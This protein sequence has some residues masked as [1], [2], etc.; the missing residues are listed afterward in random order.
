MDTAPLPRIPAQPAPATGGLRAL[1]VLAGL[2]S[3][4]LVLLGLAL[5]VLQL[6]AGQ[7]APGTGLAAAIGPTWP[8]AL[9]QLGV[10]LAGEIVVLLRGRLGHAA[11]TWLAVAV[12]VATAVVLYLAWWA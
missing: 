1:E 2:C 4:G 7:I 6:T 10:G 9:G 5:V 8:R 12:L 11:R 3:G